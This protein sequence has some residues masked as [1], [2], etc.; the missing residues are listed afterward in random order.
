MVG[1]DIGCVQ[2]IA[3]EIREREGEIRGELVFGWIK[4]V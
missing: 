2:V 4:I 1:G 3:S